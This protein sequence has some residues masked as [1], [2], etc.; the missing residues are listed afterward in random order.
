MQAQQEAFKHVLVCARNTAVPFGTQTWVDV[1]DEYGEHDRKPRTWV[2]GDPEEVDEEDDSE[3]EFVVRPGLTDSGPL[4]KVCVMGT[5]RT[6]AKI[7]CGQP[8]AIR[9]T[10]TEQ[11]RLSFEVLQEAIKEGKLGL[12][13]YE[14]QKSARVHQNRIQQCFTLTQ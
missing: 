6:G 10:P 1:I 8:V 5:V 12:K 14:D 3:R 2:C 13:Q 7:P 4:R 9:R 11:E